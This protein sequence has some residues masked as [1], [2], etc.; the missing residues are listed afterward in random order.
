MK[1]FITISI[2]ALLF[3]GLI[4]A[5]FP[6]SWF[7][8][9]YDVRYMGLAAIGSAAAIIILPRVFN[10]LTDAADAKNKKQV[11]NLFQ[12]LLTVSIMSNAL[13]DLGFYQLYKIGFQYDKLVH[14]STSLLGVFIGAIILHKL[15]E[16]HLSY[17]VVF[18]FIAVIACGIG[19]EVFERI[20]D[21]LFKTHIAGVYASDISND[22][23][24]DLLSGAI[25]AVSGAILVYCT[26]IHSD[27]FKHKLLIY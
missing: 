24:F 23:K 10:A 7:P 20:S 21:F 6:V 8:H 22:T 2:I 18:A 1:L 16:I 13:G 9:F 3:A 4:L 15:F 25:G 11:I 19:W 17:A 26:N 12:F 27:F 5:S 14:F